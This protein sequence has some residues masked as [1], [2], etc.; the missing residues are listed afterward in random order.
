MALRSCACVGKV[1]VRTTIRQQQA[2]PSCSRA[3]KHDWHNGLQPGFGRVALMTFG[4]AVSSVMGLLRAAW[5]QGGARTG[6]RR[7]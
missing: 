6:Q 2:Q 5:S 1:A 3:E 7:P 4:V